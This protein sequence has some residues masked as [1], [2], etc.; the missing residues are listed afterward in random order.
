MENLYRIHE[1]IL[2]NLKFNNVD[3][4]PIFKLEY[5]PSTSE[6]N[7]IQFL[8][9]KDENDLDS[10]LKSTVWHSSFFSIGKKINRTWKQTTN[11][12]NYDALTKVNSYK[13]F[14]SELLIKQGFSWEN[15]FGVLFILKDT[16]SNIIYK[17]RLFRP[18][19]FN[20]NSDTEVINGS[21]WVSSIKFWLPDLFN[22]LNS[23]SF[24]VEIIKFD[25]VLD[26]NDILIYPTQ[27]EVLIPDMPLSDKVQIS[28]RW[29]DSLQ[30]QITPK[31]L[32]PEYTIEQLLK[33]NFSVSE[34]NNIQ[35]QHNI[36]FLID[37]EG[38]YEHY[39]IGNDTNP[40]NSISIGLPLPYNQEKMLIEVTSMFKI[41]GLL[42][43]RYNTIL[44]DF[45]TT[46]NTYLEKYIASTNDN[47][48]LY[49]ISV[50]ETL[51]I[52][53]EII[54]TEKNIKVTQIEVPTFI[55]LTSTQN[56][57]VLD[58]KNVSFADIKQNFYIKFMFDADNA[59]ENNTILF[60][61]KTIENIYYVNISEVSVKSK[62][63]NLKEIAYKIYDVST[64]N[65]IKGGT[66]QIQK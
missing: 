37:D 5:S 52:T 58:N 8:D 12:V 59:S 14:E 6:G 2:L 53:N 41:N 61:E 25:D 22:N 39:V 19:E 7:T 30:L 31:S 54:N 36:K 24:A 45:T 40:L 44:W 21:F 49:P 23:L 26:E 18:Y 38:N 66:M 10:E 15:V 64:S 27:Y 29:N 43:T 47:K 17:S 46:M 62:E 9:L 3:V 56:I 33:W 48:V 1:S 4:K 32:L 51:N 13:Q 34:I 16:N 63:F 11:L 42:A 55:E 20:I 35:L 65:F 28:L 50:N 60:S 57:I